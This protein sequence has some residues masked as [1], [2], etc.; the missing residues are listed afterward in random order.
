MPVPCLVR[1]VRPHLRVLHILI[2]RG[3]DTAQLAYKE[4]QITTDF[5]KKRLEHRSPLF[6]SDADCVGINNDGS[7]S[8]IRCHSPLSL[9][10]FTK[11]M[12]TGLFILLALVVGVFDVCEA[13]CEGRTRV[14]N[15]CY[16]LIYRDVNDRSP[17]CGWLHANARLATI[18]NYAENEG[19]R[20][21]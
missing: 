7:W 20:A 5:M 19:V 16:G 11:N 13:V 10:F 15:H 21:T 3:V 4:Y 6:G 9:L 17:N 14:G 1:R 2:R 12:K 8:Y 18:E